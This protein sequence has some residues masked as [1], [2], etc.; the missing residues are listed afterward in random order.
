M[1]TTVVHY[2]PAGDV[3]IRVQPDPEVD[4]HLERGAPTR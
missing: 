2:R 1:A 4:I 3:K